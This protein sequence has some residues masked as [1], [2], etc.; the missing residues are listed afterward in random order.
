MGMKRTTLRWISSALLLVALML[1]ASVP[2]AAF[3]A[4]GP[5][6]GPAISAD[7]LVTQ[8]SLAPRT[9]NILQDN[10]SITISF[11]YTTS[12][13]GGV[14]IFARPFTGGALTPSYAAS[15]SPLYPV[16]TGVGSGNF[17]ITTGNVTVDQIRFQVLDAN[18][19]TLLF[20]A[21][22][23]VHYQFTSATKNV[24]SHIGLTATPNVLKRN[25]RV[26]VSFN[27]TTTLAAGVRIFARPLT[28]GSLTPS[29]AASGS[30]LYPVGTGTGSGWFTITSGAPTV[31]GVR[32][33]M[34]NANQTRL[35]FQAVV[36]VT[37]QFRAPTNVVNSITLR[38]AN[39]NILKFGD[40][41]TL[42]MSYT[43]NV[44]GGVRIFARPFTSGALT[45]NYAAHPSPLYPVGT[46]SASGWFT[47]SDGT[48]KV[49]QIRIQMWNAN[50][51]RLLFQTKIPVSY[52]FK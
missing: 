43:T 22:I 49:D 11:S 17:T 48:V 2:A 41:V 42:V 18:Q 36:P 37:Y 50:Q 30:P 35:L 45:P 52:Q 27:Y 12:E 24:I 38:P 15:G 4:P 40:R 16:G 8:I 46:G 47:I 20:E 5:A 10:D 26:A 9:P 51:T 14:R 3:A 19:T 34:W 23:P 28:G 13:A 21:F 32:F 39:P 31:T 25:Q 33:Q 7:H 44:A 6:V 1:P 29:Y